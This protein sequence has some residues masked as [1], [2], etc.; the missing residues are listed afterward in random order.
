MAT[1]PTW[2]DERIDPAL[3][4]KLTQRHVVEVML[5]S[6][7]PFFSIQ[8]LQSRVRPTVSK[9]TVRNRLDELREIDVV[10]AETY[11]ETIT[12]YYVNHP[13]SRWPLSPEGKRALEHETPLETLSLGD[14]LRLRNTAGIRTLVLAGF[15][16]S[17]LLFC[18]GVV[19]IVLTMDAPVDASHGLL[20]AAG[21]LFVVCLLLLGVERLV[22]SVR[23]DGVS[24][25]VPTPD[26]SSSK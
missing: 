5:E 19:M 20:A 1:L 15:Q 23:D 8:Q 12:L 13:E 17:L 10:A 2:I 26:R 4:K 18:V 22:R 25:A 16:L 21:N 24:G 7:R 6:D 9:E 14:F 11:P 3:D